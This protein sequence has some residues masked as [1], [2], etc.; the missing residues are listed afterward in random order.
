MDADGL[1]EGD[2]G[3]GDPTSFE[4]GFCEGGVVGGVEDAEVGE[5]G[6][7]LVDEAGAEGSVGIRYVEMDKLLNE[8][9]D[10]TGR[11]RRGG[12]AGGSA[13]RSG[14]SLACSCSGS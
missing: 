10:G 2:E 6:G 1:E 7:I 13:W 3:W 4:L 12:S 9:A 5:A 11:S 14:T 8:F